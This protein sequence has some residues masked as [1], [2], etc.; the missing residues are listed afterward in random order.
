MRAAPVL[1][2]LAACD[3]VLPREAWR[4]SRALVYLDPD[5]IVDAC[6]GAAAPRGCVDG[7]SP[8]PCTDLHV[9]ESCSATLGDLQACVDAL[10][11]EAEAERCDALLPEPCAH[12]LD[13]CEVGR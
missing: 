3:V 6:R 7:W 13:M 11:V 1:L 2:I 8:S 4:E 5:E 10:A 9:P 12:Y